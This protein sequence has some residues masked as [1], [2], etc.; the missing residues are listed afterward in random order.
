LWRSISICGL[1][2]PIS[3]NHS[4]LAAAFIISE[5]PGISF[6]PEDLRFKSVDWHYYFLL[7][8]FFA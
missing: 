5:Y 1:H 7:L 4:E 2:A 3:W 8:S 6:I